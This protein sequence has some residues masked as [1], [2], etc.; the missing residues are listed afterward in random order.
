[1]IKLQRR[2]LK[3]LPWAKASEQLRVA[4]QVWI[5]SGGDEAKLGTVEKLTKAAHKAARDATPGH[6]KRDP[7][8]LPRYMRDDRSLF[9]RVMCEAHDS[10]RKP[11][12]VPDPKGH[13]PPMH[14]RLLPGEVGAMSNKALGFR[15]HQQ[16]LNRTGNKIVTFSNGIATKNISVIESTPRR[17]V[18][19]AR[20]KSKLNRMW[21]VVK[22]D[23][24]K[25]TGPQK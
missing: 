24:V 9:A 7:S 22:V 21:K 15:S 23:G 5:D 2:R 3:T 19:V 20:K 4:M 17:A 8:R 25:W 18:A 14:M 12:S 11:G 6:R 16:R 13:Q 1:M 10:R